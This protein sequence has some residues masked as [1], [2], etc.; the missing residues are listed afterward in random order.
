LNTGIKQIHTS[1]CVYDEL[2]SLFK[3][4]I[5]SQQTGCEKDSK[6]ISRKLINLEIQKDKLYDLY[7]EDDYFTRDD[8]KRKLTQLDNKISHLTK[9]LKSLKISSKNLQLEVTSVMEA[10]K[11]IPTRF[12]SADNSQKGL[13]LR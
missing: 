10:I 3:K 5:I 12:T 2:N 4:N 11:N 13:I 1:E 9:H 7:L 8:L 6:F